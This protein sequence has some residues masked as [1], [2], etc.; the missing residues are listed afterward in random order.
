PGIEV[1]N[2]LKNLGISK[3]AYRRILSRYY[4]F[5]ENVMKEIWAAY[6]MGDLKMIRSI[7]H[8]IKGGS[9]NIGATDVGRAALALEALAKNNMGDSKNKTMSTMEIN[10]LDK[11]ISTV[12][13]SIQPL[14][15]QPGSYP[16]SE[17]KSTG[18]KTVES[19]INKLISA[20]N[21]ADPEECQRNLELL[22]N[23]HNVTMLQSV[24]E[25]IKNYD[26]DEAMETL[27]AVAK[28]LDIIHF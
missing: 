1:Q 26:F 2:T 3:K 6:E 21:M 15:E 18:K 14:L 25:K 20:I 11:T 5:H 9:N 16:E 13:G 10:D 27:K 7:A 22:K 8:S 17:E 4:K 24:E 28:S 12:L 23:T 19:I